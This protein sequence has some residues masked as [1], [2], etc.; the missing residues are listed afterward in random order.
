V[1]SWLLLLLLLLMSLRLLLL[2]VLLLRLW[3]L[4]PGPGLDAASAMPLAQLL[5]LLLQQVCLLL[6]VLHGRPA[7]CAY[8]EG[9]PAP[10]LRRLC[11]CRAGS[12]VHGDPAVQGPAAGCRCVRVLMSIIPGPRS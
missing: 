4:W 11:V 7:M 9:L 10:G 5:P 6:L 12:S 2:L 8:A 1:S 3:L